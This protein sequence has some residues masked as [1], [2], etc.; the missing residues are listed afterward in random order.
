MPQPIYVPINDLPRGE[1]DW[2]AAQLF[3]LEYQ[4]RQIAADMA[5]LNQI[6]HDLSHRLRMMELRMDRLLYPGGKNKCRPQLQVVMQLEQE[7]A[8]RAEKQRA[9]ALAEKRL[10]QAQAR[11]ARNA[12]CFGWLSDWTSKSIRFFLA[13]PLTSQSPEAVIQMLIQA[14]GPGAGHPPADVVGTALRQ[15][16]VEITTDNVIRALKEA[17][18]P[19]AGE[20]SSKVLGEALKAAMAAPGPNGFGVGPTSDAL[21]TPGASAAP[22]ASPGAMPGAAPQTPEEVVE[23]LLALVGKEAGEAPAEV[24]GAALVASGLPASRE[25]VLRALKAAG[26]ATTAEE[27]IQ[28]AMAAA[29]AGAAGAGAVPPGAGGMSTPEEVV[30]ALR[31]AAGPGAG[32]PPAQVVGV[33]LKQ[34]QVTPLSAEVVIRALKEA[35]YNEPSAQEVQAA[36]KG[37]ATGEFPEEA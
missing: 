26:R 33:A 28:K 6:G 37:A 12:G 18:G 25:N 17:A 15:A 23:T 5:T 29:A 21:K 13:P 35:G 24:L 31:T 34:A 14:A 3:L 8:A 7:N 22:G 19:G 16:G 2:H 10:A 27:D 9:K 4:L 11:S 36:L 20:P 1:M 32:R 30:F